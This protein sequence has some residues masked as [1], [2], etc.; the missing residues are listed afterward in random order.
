MAG[1]VSGKIYAAGG[2]AGIHLAV[3]QA[4]TPGTDR[5]TSR[6]PLPQ[7]RMDANGAGVINGVMYVPGGVGNGLMQRTLYAYTASS[8]TWTTKAT[9][10][11]VGGRGASGVIGGKLFVL[12]GADAG[13][14]TAKRLDR[15]DPASNSW[16]TRAAPVAFHDQPAAGVINGKFYV[17]GGL[18]PT[19]NTAV[20]E[21]YDPAINGWI[22][23]APMPTPRRAAAGAVLNGQLYVIGG[24]GSGGSPLSTVEVYN[25]ATN[26]WRT[27]S[28]LPTPG[29]TLAAAAITWRRLCGRWVRRRRLQ[30]YD[31]PSL[32]A[33]KEPNKRRPGDLAGPPLAVYVRGGPLQPS[34]SAS[35]HAGCFPDSS[36]QRQ[37]RVP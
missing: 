5:W 14:L 8:N 20:L 24:L 30:P 1:V 9:M 25:P 31:H 36:I 21:A 37:T 22:S 29:F 34:P 7:T 35:G 17:A 16:T 6:A 12:S 28:P 23:L 18:T 27:L 3:N 2:F 19:G 13:F 32:H 11:A 15:Y 33:L 26:S 10:P 4:Y